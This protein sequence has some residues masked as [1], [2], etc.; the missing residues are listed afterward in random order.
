M[1]RSTRPACAQG[2]ADVF[3]ER[4]RAMRAAGL[5]V[6]QTASTDTSDLLPETAERFLH[7]GIGW[8]LQP[9]TGRNA[10]GRLVPQS[11]DDVRTEYPL[12]WDISKYIDHYEEYTENCEDA[13]A[14]SD[15]SHPEWVRCTTSK[16]LIGPDNQIYPCHRHLYAQDERYACGSVHD[17]EM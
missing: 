11:W 7:A 12:E 15:F 17:F 3:I 5:N 14:E 16:F 9:F 2:D 8:K 1:L 4:A 10:E 6:G 13:N